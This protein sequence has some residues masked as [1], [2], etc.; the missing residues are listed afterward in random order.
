MSHEIRTPMNAIIGLAYLSL[1]TELNTKQRDYLNKI[2]HAGNSLL[3]IIN[4]I[5]DFSKI[6]A[7]KMDVDFAPF[8]L[9]TVISNMDTVCLHKAHGKGLRFIHDIPPEIP[10]Y[11][12]G[13]GL[14]LGQ[15]LINLVN[16]AIKFTESGEVAI[17]V[18]LE[19]SPFSNSSD[20]ENRAV[21]IKFSIRDTGIGMTAIQLN[22]LFSAFS[23]A[24]ASTSRR[25]G[26]TGLGLSISRQLVTL[27]KGKI[28]VKSDA[29]SGSLFEVILPFETCG[30]TAFS[31]LNPPPGPN[32]HFYRN[33]LILLV[34]DNEINQQIAVEL[35]DTIGVK[36]EVA[37]GGREALEKLEHANLKKYDLILMDLEMPDMDGHQATIAIRKQSRWQTLPIIAMTA[38]AI[39]DVKQRCIDEGMQE[40][41]TKPVQPEALFTMV[42]RWLGDKIDVERRQHSR[43]KNAEGQKLELMVLTQIDSSRGLSNM[44]GN[45]DLYFDI[46]RRFR[47]GQKNSADQLKTQIDQGELAKAQLLAHTLKGLAASIGALQVENDAMELESALGAASQISA[48]S[49]W[50]SPRHSG[51]SKSVQ[52]EVVMADI[53]TF[54]KRLNVS[55]AALLAEI[56][57]HLSSNE[58]LDDDETER[59][60]I[61][62][63]N[64]NVDVPAIVEEL[65]NLLRTDSGDSPAYYYQNRRCFLNVFDELELAQLDRHIK[66]FEFD[67]AVQVLSTSKNFSEV[68]GKMMDE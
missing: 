9:D 50:E 30:E 46:L 39:E 22:K 36:V 49:R 11:L 25:F 66:Q 26:G 56:N 42:A 10:R 2:H 38:H 18:R 34:E 4:N 20:E 8:S 45:V 65:L 7:G 3:G 68:N 14:R 43:I 1:K 12:I 67:D 5:L 28:S 29:G 23:Q 24:D 55:L 53:A 64:S 27:L 40:Y 57:Q 48:D 58:Q 44:H 31:T 13:D 63:V 16:N 62:L 15:I 47:D 59:M 54:R 61:D 21:S 52:N 60:N 51:I 41:I 6:E 33:A 35:L 19:Q 32:T 17:V 37:G